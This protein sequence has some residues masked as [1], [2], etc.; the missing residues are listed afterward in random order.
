MPFHAES[1]LGPEGLLAETLESYEYRPQQVQMAEHIWQVLQ[2]R[3]HGLIEAGTGVGK[4]WP[5]YC[6]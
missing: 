3:E 1:L 6:P 4:S 2:N 5:I